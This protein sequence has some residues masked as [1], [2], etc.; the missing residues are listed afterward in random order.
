M[1]TTSSVVIQLQRTGLSSFLVKRLESL[2]PG[3]LGEGATSLVATRVRAGTRI[4]L[5]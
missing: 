5:G 1:E 2:R 3:L 4:I